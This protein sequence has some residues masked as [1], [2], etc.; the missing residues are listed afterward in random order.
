MNS[1]HRSPALLQP[2]R[3][4]HAALLAAGALAGLLPLTA[5]AQS[6]IRWVVTDWPPLFLL[7][8]PAAGPRR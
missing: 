2:A 8:R 3:R 1:L 4:W 6:E 5:L 7:K